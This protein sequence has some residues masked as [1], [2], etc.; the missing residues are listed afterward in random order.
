MRAYTPRLIA[1][2]TIFVIVAVGSFGCAQQKAADE[3]QPDSPEAAAE[4]D[5]TAEPAEPEATADAPQEA[6]LPPT[7]MEGPVEDAT[8]EESADE[9]PAE[10]MPAEEE[11]AEQEP[12]PEEPAEEEPT[13]EEKPAEEKPA[14][15]ESAE[16]KPAEEMPA[17]EEPAEEKKQ[18]EKPVIDGPKPL[19]EAELLVELPDSANTP[20][21][22][23][24]LPDGN[25]ILSCPNFN[26]PSFPPVLM[27]ITPDDKAE[28]YYELP[29]HPETDTF[30]PMGIC[31]GPSGDLYLAD[32]QFFT[33]P[34]H[35]SRLVRIV[36]KD[37]KPTEVVPVVTGFN[38]SNAVIIRGDHIYVSE[39]ILVADSKPLVSG[40]FRFK[41]GEEGI[42]LKKPLTEDPHLIATI[43]THHPDIPFG[44]D[45]LAFDSLG[46]L[47]IG[48]FAD[49]TVH[50]L[51]FDDEGEVVSNEIYAKADFMLSAD[52]LYC[53][54]RTDDI[55]VADSMA[56]A[57][58]VVLPGGEV[59]TLARDPE[60]DG[61]GGALDQPCE[62]LMRGKEIVVANMDFP[63]PGGVNTEF[64]KPHTLSKIPLE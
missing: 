9:E 31:V 36:V 45:G 51:K 24:L 44:A 37:G 61:S 33:D 15:E 17:E 22:M 54:Q 5:D 62:V 49:G 30:G 20:D 1:W 32:N 12:A 41:L 48:N 59:Q 25:I 23:T 28:L 34:D 4:P 19:A 56:N 16:E 14:A 46:N 38:V 60:S 3:Q 52:G 6:E 43:E 26:D 7:P 42:E 21:G 64:N 63:V 13:A 50:Q 29:P 58:Q 53:D 2:L 55:Y 57:V 40:V 47:Y 18:A 39:T 8:E 11:P 35:K 10:E 27:K